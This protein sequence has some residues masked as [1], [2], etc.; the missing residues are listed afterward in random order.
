MKHWFASK[1]ETNAIIVSLTLVGIQSYVLYEL[2]GHLY[3][4][5][6][7]ADPCTVA[8]VF[9]PTIALVWIAK[10]FAS[11]RIPTAGG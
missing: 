9:A 1:I 6:T 11:V 7:K 4:L 8:T 10:T 2:N 3:D 5:L